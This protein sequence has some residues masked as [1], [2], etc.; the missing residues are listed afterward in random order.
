M[1]PARLD[2]DRRAQPPHRAQL[3]GRQ[4][5]ARDGLAAAARGEDLRVLGA[6]GVPDPR[7]GLAAVPPPHARAARPSLVRARDRGRPGAGRA[8]ARRDPRARRAGLAPLRGQGRRR[9]VELEAGQA[10]ARGALDR[11][12]PRDRGPRGVPAPV[13]PARARDPAGT[14][15]PAR[16]GRG[17]VAARADA[18]GRPSPRRAHG[19]RRERALPPSGR[20]RAAA[21][22]RRG[23]DRR[24]AAAATR[25]RRRRRAGARPGRRR[26]RRRAERRRPP[27][28][29]RQPPLG[30]RL[31]AA[32]A[33]LRP[34]DRGLQAAARARVRLLRAAAAARRPDRRPRRP[35][36]RPQDRNAASPGLPPRDGRAPLR[37]ARRGARRALARLAWPLGLDTIER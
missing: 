3:A 2:L 9:D 15:G 26:T 36:V 1:R 32:R 5:P 30:P 7:R 31:R 8:R 35:Q 14:A 18:Q 19:V 37:R 33:R 17:R 27:L 11:G 21:A 23:A 13:R 10:D 28:A 16:A 4:L 12:P 22:P 34:S 20:R 25:G 29:V 24:G 6:R